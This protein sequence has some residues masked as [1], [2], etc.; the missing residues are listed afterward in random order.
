MLT[1]TDAKFL[2]TA[3][4]REVIQSPPSVSFHSIF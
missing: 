2:L 1:I 3:L 4:A